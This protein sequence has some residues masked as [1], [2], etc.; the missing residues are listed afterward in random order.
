MLK[1]LRNIMLRNAH[2]KKYNVL[3]IGEGITER[4]YNATLTAEKKY[5]I[6]FSDANKNFF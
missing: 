4:L 6:N 1:M 2:A 5:S 3:I